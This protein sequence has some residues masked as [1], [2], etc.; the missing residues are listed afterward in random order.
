MFPLWSRSVRTFLLGQE[1]LC[2]ADG[3]LV[4]WSDQGEK[5]SKLTEDQLGKKCVFE[6]SQCIS[7]HLVELFLSFCCLF[8]GSQCPMQEM[9]PQTNVLDLLPKLKSMALADRAVFE[10]GMKAFVSYVQAYAKH[11]CNL[12]F[13]IKGNS[14]QGW[15][16]FTDFLR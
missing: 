2:G 7:H 9:K 12:I 14:Q 6:V 1:L 16:L 5:G 11:E 4:C 10:K 3:Q 8:S 13:R 15:Y